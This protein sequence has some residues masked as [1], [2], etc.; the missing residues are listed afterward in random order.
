VSC[1]AEV[2]DDVRAQHRLEPRIVAT[3][4]WDVTFARDPECQ[5]TGI[6]L[7][8]SYGCSGH[9]GAIQVQMAR[10]RAMEAL[11]REVRGLLSEDL[12][13]PFFGLGVAQQVAPVTYKFQCRRGRHRSVA[14]CELLSHALHTSGMSSVEVVHEDLPC[15]VRKRDGH[16]VEGSC[17]CPERCAFIHHDDSVY[18]MNGYLCE[19]RRIV[20]SYWAD[21]RM[22]PEPRI[23]GR[24]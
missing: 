14:V 12:L 20:R 2:T 3:R 24:Y 7:R 8:A 15:Y 19:A 1:G 18:E 22:Q 16:R 21:Y 23:R 4:T 11:V 9:C 10:A 17:G 6:A 5:R 13:S